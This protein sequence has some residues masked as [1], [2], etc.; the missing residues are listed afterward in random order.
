M[1]VSEASNF[2]VASHH[3]AAGQT[4]STVPQPDLISF[5]SPAAQE[6]RYLQVDNQPVPM[7]ATSEL[8]V[9]DLLSRSFSVS[10]VNETPRND[11]DADFAA[12]P[13]G[14]VMDVVINVA[15]NIET[16]GCMDQE[17]EVEALE[18]AGSILLQ[19]DPSE[20]DEDV[21]MAIVERTTP[22]PP[23]SDD[24]NEYERSLT[25]T[26]CRK[27]SEAQVPGDAN[28]LDLTADV[29]ISAVPV[30]PEPVVII[31]PQPRRSTRLSLAPLEVQQE[32][33][34]S[35]GSV[36][37]LE[38]AKNTA[39]RDGTT[40]R[41]TPDANNLATPQPRRSARLSLS[42][43]PGTTARRTGALAPDDPPND[44]VE[45]NPSDTTDGMTL[46]QPRRSARLSGTPDALQASTLTKPSSSRRHSSPHRNILASRQYS[47]PLRELTETAGDESLQAA[48]FKV[49]EISERT[50]GKKRAILLPESPIRQSVDIHLSDMTPLR[51]RSRKKDL[52]DVGSR[53]LGSLSPK[54]AGLLS[55]LLPSVKGPDDGSPMA[56]FKQAQPN[57]QPA[58]EDFATSSVALPSGP[59]CTPPSQNPAVAM[60]HAINST[61]PPPSPLRLGVAH[62]DDAPRSPAK[63]ITLDD[64]VAQ[65]ALSPQKAAELRHNKVGLLGAA[66]FTAR[67]NIGPSTPAKRITMEEAQERHRVRGSPGKMLRASS[68][69]PSAKRAGPM[70]SSRV[71][72]ANDR[73]G[74]PA[75]PAKGKSRAGSEQPAE[76]AQAR[77][78]A[79]HFHKIPPTTSDEVTTDLPFPLSSPV[80]GIHLPDMI[81]EEPEI[82]RSAG[83]PDPL[84]ESE[85]SRPTASEND[86]HLGVPSTAIPVKGSMRQPSPMKESRIP[87]IGAKPYSRHTASKMATTSLAR[88]KSQMKPT[89]NTLK[90]TV[91]AFLQA[92]WM[93]HVH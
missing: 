91:R 4:E 78:R 85:V 1:M 64:A 30:P 38:D 56:I 11:V 13:S 51:L 35:E 28:I 89:T 41:L 75:T 72:V 32:P 45:S 39:T 79:V 62:P 23:G 52:Q 10:P 9:D 8:T 77:A 24:D 40:F 92:L 67:T 26:D 82:I 29:A 25:T 20:E 88:A 31:S 14:D 55:T 18:V 80:K 54:S 65:G 53:A 22:K 37:P 70:E 60:T 93:I 12:H 15:E 16:G 5:E 66:V 2:H 7:S 71:A 57:L 33:S 68:A 74:A 83:T 42:P 36:Q 81:L 87:R 47:S 19:G 61:F 34:V 59:S 58:P 3:F 46:Q 21:M 44:R 50:R 63:R 86:D 48:S 17:A 43:R 69:E 27:P 76:Q 84:S 49:E 90:K 6:I 73:L